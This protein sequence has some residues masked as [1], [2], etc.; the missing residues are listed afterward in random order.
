MVGNTRGYSGKN[1][2]KSVP[3]NVKVNV[4]W[5]RVGKSFA[6]TLLNHSGALIRRSG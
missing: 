1:S 3:G 6:S 5:D 4:R 2:R